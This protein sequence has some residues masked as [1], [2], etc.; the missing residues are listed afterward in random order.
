MQKS[1]YAKAGAV[2]HF[3]G[4]KSS[5]SFN[6]SKVEQTVETKS[7]TPLQEREG[8]TLVVVLSDRFLNGVWK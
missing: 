1:V 5:S 4:H 2:I 8:E 6:F 3:L 7:H